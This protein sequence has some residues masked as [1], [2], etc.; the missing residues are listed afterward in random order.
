MIQM[1]IVYNENTYKLVPF[2]WGEHGEVVITESG[3]SIDKI[4]VRTVH[5]SEVNLEVGIYIPKDLEA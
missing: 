1:V 4:R 5:P 3:H 2:E